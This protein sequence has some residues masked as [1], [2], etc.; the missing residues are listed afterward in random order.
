MKEAIYSHV[1]FT[2]RG[3][4]AITKISIVFHFLMMSDFFICEARG[5]GT[6]FPPLNT[7]CT[8]VIYI[9]LPFTK[10]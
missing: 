2:S 6:C 7:N 5:L 9:Y 4:F 8:K 3:I 1:L 10:L